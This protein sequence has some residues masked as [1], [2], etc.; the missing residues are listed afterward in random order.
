MNGAYTLFEQLTSQAEQQ[1]NASLTSAG[2]STVALT[3]E[4][5]NTVISQ[6]LDTLSGGAY[7]QAAGVAE[8]AIRTEVEAAVKEQITASITNDNAIM[9]QIEA[10]V[11]TTYGTEIDTTAQNYVALELAK[12]YSPDN[13]ENW[14]QSPEGQAAVTAYLATA[15]GQAAVAAARTEIKAAICICGGRTTDF[16]ANGSRGNT[17]TD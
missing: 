5:Y 2:M 17:D 4:N 16:R 13:P 14:L 15:D 12:T 7:T 9:G 11:E 10:A 6:L 1:L 8:T 3:P